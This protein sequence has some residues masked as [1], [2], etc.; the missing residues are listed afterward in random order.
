MWDNIDA[1]KHANKALGQHWFSE[2][3]M[4][5]HGSEVVSELYAGQ[6]FV[7][8][9]DNFDRTRK[10]F[11]VRQAQ[12]DGGVETVGEYGGWDTLEAALV[13]VGGIVGAS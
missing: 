1:V 9:E 7:T 8:S 2:D 13:Y 11:S 3:T 6:Y 4:A 12:P 5:F 10:V